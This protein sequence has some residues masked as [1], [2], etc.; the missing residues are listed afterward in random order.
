MKIKITADS[1]CDLAKELI[2]EYD[3]GILPLYIIKGGESLKDGVEI[4]PDDIFRYVDSGA[5]ICTTSAVNIADYSKAFSEYLGTYD[6][7]IHINISSEFSA[8]CQ[9]ARVAAAEFDN[10][11]VVD[12]RNLSTGIGHLVLDAAIMA[13]S[14]MKPSDI[15]DWLNN[16]SGDLEVSFVINTLKYLYKGGRCSGLAALGANLLNLK[17]CIEVKNGKM[18]VGKKYR[19]NMDK[20]IL[21][22]I[23]DRLAGRDDLDLHRIFIT[24]TTVYPQDSYSA[25]RE[26]IQSIAKFEEII[27]TTA[28]CTISNHCGT[29]CLGILFY[30]KHAE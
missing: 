28:G 14:G 21:Q 19:G 22:Y 26:K 7:V 15:V 2:D 18:D 6:A 23:E 3:I 24:H 25:V 13:R 10:V 11:Y 16:R 12:S 9:N 5:G 27:E 8:C 20:V 30:R 29:N 1:T 17:P 4:T